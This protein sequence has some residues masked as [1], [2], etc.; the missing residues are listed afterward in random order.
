MPGPSGPSCNV[1][2]LHPVCAEHLPQLGQVT[3]SPQTVALPPH[4]LWQSMRFTVAAIAA[5]WPASHHSPLGQGEVQVWFRLAVFTHSPALAVW[6]TVQLATHEPSVWQ[7]RP[8]GQ[9]REAEQ[10]VHTPATQKGLVAGHASAQSPQ[11]SGS[12][13]RFAQP[14]A[15]HTSSPVHAALP[16]PAQTHA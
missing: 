5:H 7:N 13:C 4:T 10:G 3:V 2:A 1:F 9:S 11:W 14:S 8:F 16:L 15:Q 12:V 6:Q